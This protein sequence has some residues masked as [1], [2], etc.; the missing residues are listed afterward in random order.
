MA[1]MRLTAAL[2]RNTLPLCPGR[3]LTRRALCSGAPLDTEELDAAVRDVVCSGSGSLD[4]VGSRLDRLGVP[5]S[6]ALVGRVIDSCGG[7][8]GRRLL[9]FLAWCRSKDPGAL[10][11]EAFDR[12][13]GVL[14]RVGD[15]T[16]MRIAISEAEKDGRR[17]APETFTAVVEALVDAAKEDEAVRLFRG[18]ERLRLLPE[19]SDSVGG[20][21][22]WSSSLAMVQALCKR[23]HAREAQG[24]VWHHKNQ[25][26]VEPMASIVERSLLHGWCVHGNAKEARRVLDE[27]KTAGV[28]LGLP[29]FNDFLHCV[30]HRNLKFNPSALVPEAMDVLTEMR[31]YGVTPAASSFNILLSCLGRARRVKEAYR[32]LYLMREGNAGCSPD[33]VSYYLVVRVLYLTGRIIRG[34]GLVDAMLE[35]GVLPTAKFFHGLIGVLCGTEQVDHALDMFRLMKSCELVDTRI[36]DLLIEKLCR[37]GRFELGRELWDDAT[38]GG[39]VLGCPEDLLDPLKTELCS[40]CFLDFMDAC[41]EQEHDFGVLLKQGAEGRVFVSTFVGRECVIKERFSKKYRH[42]LLDAKLT[43][44]RL[45]AEARCMTKARKLGVPTPVLYAVDPLLHTLTFEYVDGLSVKDILLGF[46]SNGVN[47]E[48]LNDIAAQIGNAVGKLHDGGLVHG[49]LT[50][51]NMIIKNSNNQLVCRISF[52]PTSFGSYGEDHGGVQKGLEAV[53]LHPEQAGSSEAT[54]QEAH[55]GGIKSVAWNRWMLV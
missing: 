6:P 19:R 37:N 44:K 1:M 42:P 7:G 52:V 39:I 43:L 33:W 3:H 2:T 13:I 21:G 53:V 45:N 5:I 8:S 46:G 18:L 34:K 24:V 27:M 31:S 23:G 10:G 38:K 50:T 11:E 47:E 4:E 16:A 25:L 32:I 49:D 14:A 26:S 41:Q 54:G 15:L 28:P 17:M 9:R 48:R 51:S 20:D 30:C 40:K 29:S 22:V 55:D 12:A 36:Y 35:S